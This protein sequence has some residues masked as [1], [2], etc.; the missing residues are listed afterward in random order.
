MSRYP[1]WPLLFSVSTSSKSFSW[2]S[3]LPSSW[4]E[5]WSYALW[6]RIVHKPVRPLWRLKRLSKRW[7]NIMS[8]WRKSRAL[9]SR[10]KVP[11]RCS[12]SP[13][14]WREVWTTRTTVHYKIY[15][16]V[17]RQIRSVRPPCWSLVTM[18]FVKIV[19]FPTFGPVFDRFHRLYTAGAREI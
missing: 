6:A 9:K 8:L 16:I 10:P 18:W 1:L 11:W 4:L 15:A 19:Q 17:T 3:Y 5:S 14:K 12:R 7:I 2:S 13:L